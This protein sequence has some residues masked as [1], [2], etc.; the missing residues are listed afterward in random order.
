MKRFIL[1]CFLIGSLQSKSQQS[2]IRGVVS[3][4]NSET[5]T[6]KRQ[7]V[8]NAQVEDDFETATS[9][10]T[11]NLGFFSLIYVGKA[12]KDAVSFQIKK[13]G[14][15]VVNID[16]LKAVAGQKEIVKISMATPEKIDKYRKEIYRIGKAESEKKLE[17]LVQ[18]K[19]KELTDLR[20]SS[21][22]NQNKINKLEQELAE[23]EKQRNKI[24]EEAQEL[25]RKYAP[26]NLDDASP[27]F[28]E[29]FVLFQRGNLDSALFI[30]TQVN[31]A[32]K[33]Y[34]ILEERRKL[35]E[36]YKEITQRDS[37]QKHRA[38]D[39][40]EALK[41]KAD[42]HKTRYEFDSAS[43]CYVLLIKLDSLNT[44][45]LAN[46]AQF[47]GWLNQHDNAI[48]Y[49]LKVLKITRSNSDTISKIYERD[50][51]TAQNYLGLLYRDK[52]D[53][54]NAEAAFLEALE[55]RKRLAKAN[56]KTYESEVASTQNNLGLI[57]VAKN[58]YVKA[59]AT[60]LEA[61]DVFN[62]LAKINPQTY[63]PDVATTQNNL[64]ILYRATNN[65]V[66][67]DSAY[68]AALDI[69]NRLAKVDPQTYEPFVARTQNNLGVLYLDKKDYVR[70]EAAMLE[71]LKVYK[72][73]ARP[74]PQTY[75]PSV[76]L[77]QINLGVLYVAKKD[78]VKAQAA[79]LEALEVYKRLAGFNYQTYEPYVAMAQNNIGLLYIELKNYSEAEFF[80]IESLNI[81]EKWM[82]KYAEVYT[83]KVSSIAKNLLHLYT[84]LLETLEYDA[85]KKPKQGAF[86]TVENIIVNQSKKDIEVAQALS[87]YHGNHSWYLLFASKFK[88]AEL[89]A[90]KGLTIKPGNTW[91]KTNLASSLL[92]Q[93][94]YQDALKVYEELKLLKDEENKSYAIT[95][96]EDLDELEK[97]GVTHKDV[98]KIRVVLKE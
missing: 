1:L 84:T 3:I 58:D 29:V 96:L 15:Q 24:E 91:I 22:Q 2:I 94:K 6:G 72:R 10:T 34:E 4:H 5:E 93:G 39:V 75:E 90:Q 83:K 40:G 70:S 8:A 13:D 14:L 42:L 21:Q 74:N 44:G 41:F 56:S 38:E 30:L 59:E 51:A 67:A 32:N 11:D 95:C 26:V 89:A 28:R 7:Y 98:S 12:E 17:I 82:N 81:H 47:L 86:A 25:G 69:F 79:Y 16:A 43:A 77:T 65:Y 31:L 49:Y 68:H 73:L 48:N 23:I 88:E 87:N 64:G 71:T 37:V 19:N 60:Y 55:I 78:Y 63:E 80:L 62:R 33:V 57:Y 85:F 9:Q 54:A 52:N 20:K 45:Y 66:R 36:L 35:A 76:A 97:N 50:V 53:Y 92:F 46:Y 61:L 27:L 18:K